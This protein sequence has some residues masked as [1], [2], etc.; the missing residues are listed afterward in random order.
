MKRLFLLGTLLML[1]AIVGSTS[2]FGQTMINGATS[3]NW[4]SASS[5]SPMTVPNNNGSNTYNVNLLNSPAVMRSLDINATIDT[6]TVGQGSTL[7]SSASV[8]GTKL[9]TT[10]VTDGGDIIFSNNNTLT[11]NGA[12]TINNTGEVDLDDAST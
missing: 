10:G 2:L 6:L 12:M 11:V 1:G 5:W 9:T 8:S 7:Q 3:G 4:S